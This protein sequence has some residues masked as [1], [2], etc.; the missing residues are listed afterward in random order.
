MAWISLVIAGFFEIVWVLALKYSDGLSNWWP[1]VIFGVAACVS[2]A[3]LSYALKTLPMGTAYATWTGIG[4]VGIAIV[5]MLWCKEPA[6][7]ARVLCIALI[8][9]GI[10]GL[11]LTS[12]ASASVRLPG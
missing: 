3:F 8:V 10:V 7:L 4:A 5:G 6:G 9:A 1:S 12:P 2:F 11:K